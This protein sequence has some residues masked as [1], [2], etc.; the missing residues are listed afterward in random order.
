MSDHRHMLWIALIALVC[1]GPV[2][3][4]LVKLDFEKDALDNPITSGQVI[5]DEYALWG[6]TVDAYNRHRTFDLAMAF[7]SANPTGGDGDLATPGYHPTNTLSYGNMLIL[8]ERDEGGVADDEG[9]SF[10]GYLRFTFDQVYRSASVVLIDAEEH[11]GT[12]ELLLDG[13]VQRTVSIDGVGDNSVQMLLL[14]GTAFD[15]LQVNPAGSIAVA[16]VVVSIA[17]QVPEPASLMVSSLGGLLM[18][19]RRGRRRAD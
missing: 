18:L 14:G 3:A 5:D 15:T 6:V 12:V 9:R 8:A 7:D 2:N 11:G 1:G 16:E 17:R 10:P 4:S 13:E 19:R